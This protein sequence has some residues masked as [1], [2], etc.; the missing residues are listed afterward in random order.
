MTKD[1]STGCTYVIFLT[2][3]C[4]HPTE[5]WG[6]PPTVAPPRGLLV[7]SP[8]FSEPSGRPSFG[9]TVLPHAASV[10]YIPVKL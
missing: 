6:R 5:R 10:D 1:S 9:T 7:G 2:W 3:R 8:P 4:P